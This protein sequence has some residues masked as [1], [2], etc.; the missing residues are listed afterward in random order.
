V[1][2]KSYGSV[3]NVG[4]RPTIAKPDVAGEKPDLL[5]ETHLFDFDGDL[6]DKKMEVLFIEKL[7]DERRF[8]DVQALVEQI[9]KDESK[10][11]AILRAQGMTK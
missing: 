6:Y 3:S 10:A 5:V 7:R 9:Q 2:G 4:Y 11:R 1:D 8:P